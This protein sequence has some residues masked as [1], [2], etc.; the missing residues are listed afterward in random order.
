[1]MTGSC[2]SSIP[3]LVPATP[4]PKPVNLWQFS[5][6]SNITLSNMHRSFKPS[7]LLGYLQLHST[8]RHTLLL[9]MCAAHLA[10]QINAHSSA[11]PFTAPTNCAAT[12][13]SALRNW[14]PR[15][16]LVIC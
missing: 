8:S 4:E 2:R 13:G 1:M 11:W 10:T 3:V 14:L 9:H 6:I 7:W 5:Q 16:C 15:Y 12:L